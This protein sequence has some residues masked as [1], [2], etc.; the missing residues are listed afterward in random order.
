VRQA[1]DAASGVALDGNVGRRG[2]PAGPEVG[3][4]ESLGTN[5]KYTTNSHFFRAV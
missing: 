3:G 1:R 5:G 4:G 2:A